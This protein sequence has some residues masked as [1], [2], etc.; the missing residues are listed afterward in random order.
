MKYKK[1]KEI[2]VAYAKKIAASGLT[3][4]TGGNL[5]LRLPEANV[6]L[7]TPSGVEYQ[8]MSA[9][10]VCVLDMD[11]N[12]LYG[13]H[14]ESTETPFH[15][16][17]YK[18]RSNIN[19]VVHTHSTYATVLACLEWEIPPVHYLAGFSGHRVPVAPYALFGSTELSK[20][21]M[22]VIGNRN[23]VLLANH[24]LVTVGVDLAMACTCAEQIEFV[25]KIYY[26]TRCAGE[27][28]ILSRTEMD[29]V[30]EKFKTYGFSK[31]K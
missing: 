8:T 1:E 23:A 30:L 5:S 12:L 21:I 16:A 18:Y 9:D 20:N 25:A 27:P 17:L 4:G 26:L 14:E 3:V 31:N 11:G 19:A 24:G 10:D 28:Q 29:R 15:L 13:E 6:V 7:M 2:V 22:D